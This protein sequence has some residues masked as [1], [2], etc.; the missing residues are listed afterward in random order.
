MIGASSLD[1][2]LRAFSGYPLYI[3]VIAVALLF[4]LPLSRCIV[5]VGVRIRRGDSLELGPFRLAE[6]ELI[7]TTEEA[8]QRN[9]PIE[10]VF[11]NPDHFRLLFKVTGPALVKSTKAMEV[12]GG[13][14]VLVSSEHRSLDGEWTSA[15]ALE[16]V[17][18]VVVVDDPSQP[19]GL[20]LGKAP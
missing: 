19:R 7:T 8:T 6:R 9:G 18:N 10:A 20:M 5:A 15:E 11:G 12:A 1:E 4:R 16:F 14:L 17:P 13:C 3:T 2:F